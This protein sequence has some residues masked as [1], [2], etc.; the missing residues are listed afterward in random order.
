MKILK[1]VPAF[2]KKQKQKQ[3]RM[4]L[5]VQSIPEF[6][7]L[8]HVQAHPYI[9]YLCQV[10]PFLN[11]THL[12]QSNPRTTVTNCTMMTSQV[13]AKITNA[14]QAK[15]FGAARNSSGQCGYLGA[16]NRAHT[17]RTVHRTG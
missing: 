3:N 9:S 13:I 2:T 1:G 6:H 11:V 17:A 12:C 4:L 5:D 8:V 7:E 10:N 16:L 14:R 15:N